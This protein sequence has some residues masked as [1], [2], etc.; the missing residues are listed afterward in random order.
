MKTNYLLILKMAP[1][2]FLLRF[3]SHVAIVDRQLVCWKLIYRPILVT[4]LIFCQF[5]NPLNLLKRHNF[6][7]HLV[8]FCY[9]L[10]TV[11]NLKSSIYK[12]FI[13]SKRTIFFLK[14]WFRHLLSNFSRHWPFVH[15]PRLFH[16]KHL[17][18]HFQNI[19]SSKTDSKTF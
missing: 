11:I 17:I 9:N 3:R 6:L 10:E 5:W 18:R 12:P 1:H 15:C 8:D 19:F 4:L 14:N 2:P 16:W 7:L 13:F